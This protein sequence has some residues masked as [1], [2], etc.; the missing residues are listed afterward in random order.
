MNREVFK[1]TYMT[2]A[3]PKSAKNVSKERALFDMRMEARRSIS[4]SI[5]N[6][7]K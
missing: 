6:G 5:V 1:V 7:S 3:K 4:S 2:F